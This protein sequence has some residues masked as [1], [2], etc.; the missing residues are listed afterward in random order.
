MLRIEI[1]HSGNSAILRC[2][3]RIVQGD[4]LDVLRRTA[5]SRGERN[6]IIDVTDVS[7]I[8]AGGLGVLAELQRWAS[9]S[10]RTLTLL[11]PSERVC[12]V[13]AATNLHSVLHVVKDL[14]RKPEFLPV[15]SATW[16][17][18]ICTAKVIS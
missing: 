12:D 2:S 7:S 8:D 3:G 11:N 13:L 1:Q 9:T 14:A 15:A 16:D 4:G 10:A 6:L 18:Q 5:A 17:L